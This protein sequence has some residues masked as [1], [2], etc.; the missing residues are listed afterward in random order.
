MI[1]YFL[2]FVRDGVVQRVRNHACR[3]TKS[4]LRHTHSLKNITY[5]L[6]ISNG[7]AEVASGITNYEKRITFLCSHAIHLLPW[8]IKPRATRKLSDLMS[9][10]LPYLGQCFECINEA[11]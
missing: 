6:V 8:S 11:A 5:V 10:P 7:T 3:D 4:R 9:T 2:P 1:F